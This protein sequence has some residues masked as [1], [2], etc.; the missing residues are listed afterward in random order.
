MA[1]RTKSD[2]EVTDLDGDEQAN[3]FP[4]L[5][6]TPKHKAVLK[7]ANKFREIELKREVMKKDSKKEEDDAK[8]E[9]I[10]A[11]RD[12]ELPRFR[13]DGEIISLDQKDVIKVKKAK[14]KKEEPEPSPV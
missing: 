3:L 14:P 9:L 8:K 6:K 4:E 7:A 1:K 2:V 10:A 5:D 11:M 13:L 12:A